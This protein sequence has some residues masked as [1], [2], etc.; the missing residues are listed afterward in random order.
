MD[1]SGK[2][3][4]YT[5]W[6]CDRDSTGYYGKR[7]LNY[8]TMYYIT[9]ERLTGLKPMPEV[10]PGSYYIIDT[11]DTLKVRNEF[12]KKADFNSFGFR[13]GLIYVH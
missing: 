10:V 9:R 8:A 12:T 13:S 4:L 6:P 11:Y 3:P 5:F 2:S 7:I 1:I